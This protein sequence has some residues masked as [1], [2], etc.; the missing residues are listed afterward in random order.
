MPT[1]VTIVFGCTHVLWTKKRRGEKCNTIHVW[2]MND[3]EKV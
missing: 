3:D 2:I 1:K